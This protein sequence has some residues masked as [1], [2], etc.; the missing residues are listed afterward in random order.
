MRY[1][2]FLDWVTA[3]ALG[4]GVAILIAATGGPIWAALGIGTTV[5]LLK[6]KPHQEKERP[7]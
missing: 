6:D 3:V 5:Y 2:W 4:A 1:A 7:K